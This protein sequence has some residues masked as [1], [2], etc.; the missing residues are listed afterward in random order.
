VIAEIL[1]SNVASA[2]AYGDPDDAVLFPGEELMIARAVD[3][4][5]RAFTT[6]RAC[7][8]QALS[9]LGVGPREILA[10]QRGAPLWPADIV[11]SITHCEGYRAG[12]VAWREEVACIGIDAEPAGKELRDGVL[13]RIASNWERA[14]LDRLG[15]IRPEIAWGRLMFSAKEA[16]YKAW[17]PLTGRWL[18]F[19]Q[20]LVTLHLD[21]SFD[22]R[23]L[24]PGPLVAGRRR[25]SFCGRWL[26]RDDLIVT[27]IA[28]PARPELRSHLVPPKRHARPRRGTC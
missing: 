1:P 25:A 17:Y 27:A 11:G 7:A 20:A 26:V 15:A 12:A 2:F 18:G 10:D 5:R 9:G 4:R 13:R 21:G 22:A 16:V 28:V 24:V 3:A 6:G 8:R 14:S 23:L 19:L